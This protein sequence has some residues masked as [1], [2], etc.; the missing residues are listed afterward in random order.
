MTLGKLLAEDR[1]K[2]PQHFG[3]PFPYR[4]IPYLMLEVP[5]KEFLSLL[6]FIPSRGFLMR[7]TPDIPAVKLFK[8]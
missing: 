8:R 1:K 6:A 4:E 2:N 3:Y 7:K 5:G